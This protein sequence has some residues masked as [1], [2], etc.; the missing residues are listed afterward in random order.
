[1]AITTIPWDDGSGDNIYL[2]A[3]SQVGDGTVSVTSDANTGA[4]RSK[5]V[6]FSA[7][8]VSPVTLTVNQDAGQAGRLPAG[9]TEV[10]YI[11]ND[12]TA[13]IQPGQNATSGT[14]VHITAQL[15]TT[16]STTSVLVGRGTAGGH[17]FGAV[18]TANQ[19]WGLGSSSGQYIATVATTK[20]SIVVT[21]S[22]GRTTKAEIGADSCSR[23]ANSNQSGAITLF[24]ATNNSSYPFKG[25]IYGDVLIIRSG[26]TVFQGVPCIDPSNVVGLYDL[27]SNTFKGPYN[28]AGSFIAGPPV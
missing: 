22:N 13:R 26:S 10:E 15:V 7:T 14:E 6:T 21:F 1:M 23:S 12:G 17:Y 11:E 9:Y 27:K 25:K 4:A 28:G 18:P 5:V 20:S 2:S 3:A 8:G 16:S 19:Y 24:N